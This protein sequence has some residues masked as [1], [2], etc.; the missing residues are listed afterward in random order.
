MYDE[1]YEARLAAFRGEQETTAD[2]QE[3]LSRYVKTARD[4]QAI[5]PLAFA[6][7]MDSELAPLTLT[8]VP[9]AKEVWRVSISASKAWF[10][11]QGV[12]WKYGDLAICSPQLFL[13][14]LDN[15][16]FKG[17]DHK[18]C[19]TARAVAD[20][21]KLRTDDLDAGLR[22]FL[23]AKFVEFAF[24]DVRAELVRVVGRC[25]EAN[26]YAGARAIMEKS[27]FDVRSSAL[28][29]GAAVVAP[30][31][32][33][34]EAADH[35]VRRYGIG[36]NPLK[37][38]R[39]DGKTL[40]SGLSSWEVVAIKNAYKERSRPSGIINTLATLWAIFLRVCSS[41]WRKVEAAGTVEGNS[42]LTPAEQ[43]AKTNGCRFQ[44]A[45][46]KGLGENAWTSRPCLQSAAGL[47]WLCPLRRK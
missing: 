3:G 17:E 24:P 41:M 26:D 46:S 45:D 10:E 34:D 36:R 4:A 38:R 11:K 6:T 29:N 32:F 16:F 2:E 23:M 43:R 15:E 30:P 7:L 40:E 21:F 19:A 31:E 22:R 9:E 5:N 47:C 27:R 42:T 35:V 28:L 8:P 13:E 33:R 25:R 37:L 14:F 39:A 12:A 20:F 44:V 1:E 18:K